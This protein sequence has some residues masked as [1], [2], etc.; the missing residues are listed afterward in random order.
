MLGWISDKEYG[1]IGWTRNESIYKKFEI[2][3]MRIK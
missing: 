1:E 2:A 3:L